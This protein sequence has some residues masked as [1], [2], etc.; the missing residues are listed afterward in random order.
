[1]RTQLALCL[2]ALL[3]TALLAG[4]VVADSGDTAVV[5]RTTDDEY[6]VLLYEHDGETTDQRVV[7]LD[8][9]P[10]E[11]QYEGAVVKRVDGGY[12]YDETA[13]HQ[14]RSASAERF[15]RL[16]RGH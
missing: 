16:T 7:D 12:E 9:L 8:D 11:A 2:V 15:D 14:R 10:D 13:S 6:A 3:S 1:M 4:V 5:D